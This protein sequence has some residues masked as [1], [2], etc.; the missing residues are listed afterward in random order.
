[1]Y[2][3]YKD[4]MVDILEFEG[5]TR[6]AS[7]HIGGVQWDQ[8]ASL[9]SILVDSAPPWATGGQDVSGDNLIMK[10]NP[11]T[12]K[13]LWNLNITAVTGAKY[14]GFQDIEHDARGNTYIV[15]TFPGTIMKVDPEGKAVTPWYLPSPLNHTVVGFGGLAAVGDILLTNDGDGQIYKFDMRT[16]KGKPVLVPTIP[17]VIYDD[18]DAVYL[19]PKYKGTVLLV[20]SHFSGIQ[21]L[22]SKDAKWKTA[23]HLGTIPNPKTP[24]TEGSQVTGAV[25]MGSNSVYIIDEWFADPWVAGQTAGNRSVFSMPDITSEIEKLLRTY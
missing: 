8:Y 10:Y 22:R 18:T 11:K 14:G 17:K 16:E 5:I 6:S 9:V 2:D 3:P 1:M 25:Q 13:I 7:L 21:V 24:V 4:E 15:G 20:S 19:P 12:K 23:E